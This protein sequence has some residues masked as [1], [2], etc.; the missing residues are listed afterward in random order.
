MHRGGPAPP[1]ASRCA[2]E[3]HK[4][5]LC[6]VPPLLPRLEEAH[7]AWEPS[8]TDIRGAMDGNI[9]TLH[10]LHRFNSVTLPSV[11]G[12]VNAILHNWLECQW[13]AF[14]GSRLTDNAASSHSVTFM[15]IEESHRTSIS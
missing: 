13:I 10:G 12:C 4:V 14:V 3:V 5:A 1:Q 8:D 9:F 11:T 15:W 2:S 7:K 6:A